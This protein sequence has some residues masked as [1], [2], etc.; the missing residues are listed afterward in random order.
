MVL[1]SQLVLKSHEP[2]AKWAA[3]SIDELDY[4]FYQGVLRTVRSPTKRV[5]FELMELP[6]FGMLATEGRWLIQDVWNASDPERVVVED[7]LRASIEWEGE[8]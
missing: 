2:V 6:H 3:Q 7:R 1:A 5:T 4:L 8:D